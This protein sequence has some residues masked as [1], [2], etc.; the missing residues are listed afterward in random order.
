[1]PSY[2]ILSYTTTPTHPRTHSRSLTTTCT[3]HHNHNHAP[4]RAH[5][6]ISRSGFEHRRRASAAL[7]LPRSIWA[8]DRQAACSRA[9]P[10]RPVQCIVSQTTPGG[11]T[12]RELL[13]PCFKCQTPRLMRNPLPACFW[14]PTCLFGRLPCSWSP[15]PSHASRE[16]WLTLAS[17]ANW[18]GYPVSE[19]VTPDDDRP[20]HLLLHLCSVLSSRVLLPPSAVTFTHGRAVSVHCAVRPCGHGAQGFALSRIVRL[21]NST[22]VACPPA[23]PP[24]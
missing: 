15:S 8:R 18:Q 22:Q 23:R 17:T 1:M 6:V 16:A 24:R 20:R 3:Q 4:K 11:G 7:S 2:A 13:V 14:K 5:A 10:C 12:K 9:L 21:T 19:H